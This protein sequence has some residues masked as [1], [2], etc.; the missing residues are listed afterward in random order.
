MEECLTLVKLAIEA[1]FK[2]KIQD[3]SRAHLGAH[4]YFGVYVYFALQE[5]LT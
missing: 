1:K 2:Q 5:H 4:V 3:F